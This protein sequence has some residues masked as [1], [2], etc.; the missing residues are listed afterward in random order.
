MRSAT[1]RTCVSALVAAWMMAAVPGV[2][3]AAEGGGKPAAAEA[4]LSGVVN[5]N[6]ATPEELEL[7]PGIGPAKAQAIVEDRKTNGP[8][9][10][11]EDLMRV[12][13]IG[14]RGFEQLRPHLAVQGNTTARAGE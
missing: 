3:A 2:G 11:V 9:Q 14:E 4:K 8:Y 10:K 6:T 5:L 7:L 12:P 13:G 1:L